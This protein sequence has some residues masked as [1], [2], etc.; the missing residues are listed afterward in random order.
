[1]SWLSAETRFWAKVE[2]TDTCWLWTG[3]KKPT[4]YGLLWLDKTKSLAAHRFAYQLFKGPLQEG[5]V[6]DHL[7]RNPSCVNP[8][9]LEQVTQRI[10]NL[11]ATTGF[12]FRNATRTHCPK[13]H[14]YDEANTQIYS[15]SRNCKTCSRERNHN[16]LKEKVNEP[17]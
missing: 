9:H 17:A 4:G 2:K 10:N 8:D 6:I 7:C 16:K 13:G 15:G 3:S 5:L 12:A 1:M 14:A 11:R